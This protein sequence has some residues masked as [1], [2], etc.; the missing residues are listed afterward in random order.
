M[1]FKLKPQKSSHNSSNINKFEK[2]EFLLLFLDILSNQSP[3]I[4]KKYFRWKYN[5]LE[6]KDLPEI[7]EASM[8][9][10]KQIFNAYDEIQS[11]Y[12]DSSI[13][14]DIFIDMGYQDSSQPYYEEFFAS[15][16]DEANKSLVY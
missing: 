13:L 4:L 8:E 14:K 15:V 16:S 5:N 2:K 9:D 6:E 10:S 3:V 12:I 1:L 11:G 7:V